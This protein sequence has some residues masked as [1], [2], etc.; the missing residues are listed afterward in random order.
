M[1]GTA[2]IQASGRILEGSIETTDDGLVSGE[3]D[4]SVMS[5]EAAAAAEIVL[6]PEAATL[7]GELGASVNLIEGS[8]SGDL[9]ITP[10]RVISKAVG[11]WSWVTGNDSTFELS[12]NWDVGLIVGGELSAQVGAQAG[13]EGEL[14]HRDG[15]A[16]A[17][18]GAKIG[19]GLGVG[20]KGRV[21]IA[22]T[23]VIGRGIRNAWGGIK[24]AWNSDW[25]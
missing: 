14:S 16:T 23:D 19:L 11:T 20:V 18:A 10:R 17:E 22:G 4:G 12:E 21:G 24:S 15:R 6:S 13:V 3:A 8:I 7:T 5:A 1:K 9:H 25:W 2:E